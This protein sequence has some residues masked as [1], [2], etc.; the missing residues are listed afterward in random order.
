MCGIAGAV[1]ADFSYEQ[2]I[3]T[4][5]HRGP[6]EQ[7]SYQNKNVD[8]FH[9]RLSILDIEGGKQPMQLHEK[10]TILFNGEIY[11]H[12][13]IRKQFC[14]KGTTSSDT[15]TLLL[16]YDRFGTDFLQFLDGMFAFVIYDKIKNQLL[17]ARDRAGEKPFYYFFDQ[18]KFLFASEL[19]CLKTMVPLE[20]EG[21]N[22]F[23][24]LR[25]GSFYRQFT[26]YKN[27][28]E[29]KAGSFLI[30]DCNSLSVNE[31][32][33]WN[34]NDFYQKENKDSLEESIHNTDVFLHE[35]VKRRLESS[36]L[37][38]GSF[39]SGGIDSGLVTAIAT[40]YHQNLK[41]FTVSFAGEYDEA[42]L[43]KLVAEKYKTHHTEIKISF[44]NL[45]NDLE[46]ILS[47]YGEPFFDSSVIPSYYVSREA[48]KFVTVILN[49]DGADELF[50]GYRRYVPF[51]KYDFFKKNFLVKKGASFFK[52]NLPSAKN[53]KSLYNYLY[54]LAS[55]ASNSDLEIYLSAGVDI[56]E[57]YQE[58]IIDPGFDYLEPVKKDF[59]KIA[60][61]K[62]SGLKKIMNLDFDTVLFSDF[63]VKMDIATMANSQEGRSAFL[64][65]E[66]LEYIP[67]VPDHYKIK[68]KTTKYM[69]R[70]LAVNYLPK[71][72]IDQP[73]RGFEI[74]LKN[75]I[76]NELKE[77]VFDYLSTNNNFY[78]N[79]VQQN[80]VHDLLKKKIKI[81]AEKRAKILWTLLSMEIW[82]KKVYHD[83]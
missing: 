62:L 29:L 59:D 32:R 4:L 57:E 40:E 70:Q 72:L 65:K 21:T 18:Q 2:V 7:N 35:A 11:N 56:F 76:E 24:Y 23:Q 41:T 14:L 51:A 16:L 5:R 55:L 60:N 20:I 15:E 45:K 61:S 68:G 77:P 53:K 67:T 22:F 74:P 73:K 49:G 42:P 43:A 58:Y 64:S 38:V 54:R 82:Y 28:T 31:K 34:I 17:I 30:V 9:L 47:N 8:L 80:F 81:S 50:G 36:D 46:K 69:L 26:P 12:E 79:F 71:E 6:D 37:E 66:L 63:L 27:V 19:N 1:N 78:K 39:L 52:N 13:A 48:K 44:E 83:N 25:L 33:W 3:K 75:W 10:Y